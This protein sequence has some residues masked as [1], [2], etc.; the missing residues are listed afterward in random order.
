MHTRIRT[1]T[2]MHVRAHTYTSTH[3]PPHQPQ[4]QPQP[5]TPPLSKINKKS[6]N[7]K[8]LVRDG[9]R[10]RVRDWRPGKTTCTH[11]SA[12]T[13]TCMHVP[14]HT[15]PRIPLPTNHNSNPNP[16]PLPCPKK[17]RTPELPIFLAGSPLRAKTNNFP[18]SP[19][20][21]LYYPVQ[22]G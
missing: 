2:H 13:H 1:Y 3:S 20:Q 19:T 6:K 15:R 21:T 16:I 22:Y 7:Q 17:A 18:G 14:I 11:V 12:R 10:V 4:L 5:Y 8:I 9:V